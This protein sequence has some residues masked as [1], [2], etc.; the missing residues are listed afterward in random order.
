MTEHLYGQGDILNIKELKELGT[1]EESPL[2]KADS[3]RK[4]KG[5]AEIQQPNFTYSRAYLGKS[6]NV[7]PSVAIHSR[8]SHFPRR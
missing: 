5:E 7:G 6:S 3:I 4:G 8:G 1:T 2:E